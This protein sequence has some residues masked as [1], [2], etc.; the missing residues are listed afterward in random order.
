MRLYVLKLTGFRFACVHAD[1]YAR[2]CVYYPYTQS[3]VY[4]VRVHA[5][6]YARSC[7]YYAYTQSCVY[8]V[9]VRADVCVRSLAYYLGIIY[10]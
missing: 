2:S 7:V 5:D 6:V 9:R 1:V 8:R 3:F 10:L 4:R